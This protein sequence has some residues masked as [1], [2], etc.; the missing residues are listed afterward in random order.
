MKRVRLVGRFSLVAA[1]LAIHPDPQGGIAVLFTPI[2][3]GIAAS[4]LLVLTRRLL[5]RNDRAV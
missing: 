2:Y 1:A 5:G 3:Q 4:V